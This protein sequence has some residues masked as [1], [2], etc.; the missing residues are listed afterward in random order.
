MVRYDFQMQKISILPISTA[1]SF[2]FLVFSF[3]TFFFTH[4]ST[5]PK[6]L[7]RQLPLPRLDS[8]RAGGATAQ[9]SALQGPRFSSGRFFTPDFG[10]IFF[11]V[12]IRFISLIAYCFKKNSFGQ[13][14]SFKCKGAKVFLNLFYYLHLSTIY[15]SC[16][17]STSPNL[18][19]DWLVSSA[20]KKK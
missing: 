16:A 4:F 8:R 15:C 5:P 18:I 13:I 14:L 2:Y 20:A 7:P 17:C 6:Q 1:M 10:V 19:V 3:L 9:R 12:K 11:F